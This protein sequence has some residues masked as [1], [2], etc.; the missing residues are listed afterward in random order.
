MLFVVKKSLS[1]ETHDHL[2]FGFS[3][4]DGGDRMRQISLESEKI[5]FSQFSL[6]VSGFDFD[7]ALQNRDQF[8]G[9][10]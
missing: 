9:A 10:R 6:I 8:L 4:G 2:K 7:A 1:W 5:A 3:S